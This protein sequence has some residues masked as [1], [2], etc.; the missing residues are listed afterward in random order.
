MRQD[1]DLSS[2]RKAGEALSFDIERHRNSETA[3]SSFQHVSDN[4]I[5][6][7]K[8]SQPVSTQRHNAVMDGKNAV[9]E[10]MK[11]SLKLLHHRISG[12]L[13]EFLF[14]TTEPGP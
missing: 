7:A 5:Q 2:V 10:F 12:N 11:Q 1:T 4:P 3:L 8:I 14:V 6:N 13:L 9:F